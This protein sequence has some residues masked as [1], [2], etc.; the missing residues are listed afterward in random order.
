MLGLAEDVVAQAFLR[1]AQ[2]WAEQVQMYYR[3]AAEQANFRA[4]LAFCLDGRDAEKGLRL[5]SALRSPWVVQGD[6]AEGVALVRQVPRPRR[7]GASRRSR[8][9]P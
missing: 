8:P 1:N 9:R 6:V 7:M 5:C 2:P 4:A 3:I